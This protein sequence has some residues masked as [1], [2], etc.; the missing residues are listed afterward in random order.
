MGVGVGGALQLQ[1]IKASSAVGPPSPGPVYWSIFYN[2]VP[3]KQ[4]TADNTKTEEE[5]DHKVIKSLRSEQTERLLTAADK[6]LN[7]VTVTAS[8]DV[9][10]SVTQTGN[11]FTIKAQTGDEDLL[12]S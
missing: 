10:G 12:S 4:N 6:E 11:T 5:E 7:A 2:A 9:R 1:F 8:S 3:N